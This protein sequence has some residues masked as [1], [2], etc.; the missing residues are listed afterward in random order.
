MLSEEKDK[1]NPNEKILS[2]DGNF[3]NMQKAYE[4]FWNK[5]L[6]MIFDIDICLK[7]DWCWVNKKNLNKW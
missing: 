4:F 1:R 6:R 7:K 2:F 3:Q 5:N